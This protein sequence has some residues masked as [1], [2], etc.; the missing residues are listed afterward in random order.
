MDMVMTEIEPGED[1]EDV[2]ERIDAAVADGTLSAGHAAQAKQ[3]LS[4]EIAKLL[5]RIRRT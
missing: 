5:E 3:K 1:L 4:A 2:A